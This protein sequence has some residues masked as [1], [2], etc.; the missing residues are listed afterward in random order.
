MLDRYGVRNRVVMDGLSP[1]VAREFQMSDVV[2]L[3]SD[4]EGFSNS[5]LQAMYY[6]KPVV[7]CAVGGN[8][9][10]IV[11]GETGFLI[12]PKNP[13][14]MAE[15][16]RKLVNDPDLTKRMGTAGH[17]R[18]KKEFTLNAMLTKTQDLFEH[19]IHSYG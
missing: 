11:E 2:V 15:A 6:R 3:P 19:I 7:A 10:A 17:A 4:T 14:A 13:A 18:A 8:P 9:E 16:L 5:I 1:A 12:P